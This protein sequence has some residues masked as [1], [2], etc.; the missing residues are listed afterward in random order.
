MNS[1]K[2]VIDVF[3]SGARKGWDI[4]VTSIVPNVLFAFVLIEIMQVSGFMGFMEWL[5]TPVMAIFGLPGAAM[6]VVLAALMSINGGG[7]VAAAL[8]ASGSLEATHVTMMV[9][10]IMLMG[11]KVQ[12]LGRMLGTAGV[13]KRFFLPLLGVSILNGILSLF[14]MRFLMNFF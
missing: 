4:A 6:A 2:N 11:A 1:D 14:V 9:P 7:G 12:F 8:Y 10:M 3:V 13:Q 5:C